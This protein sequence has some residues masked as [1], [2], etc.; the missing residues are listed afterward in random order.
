MPVVMMPTSTLVRMMPTKVTVNRMAFC[1]VFASMPAIVPPS[2]AQSIVFQMEVSR[3][4]SVP[5]T[6]DKM[7]PKMTQVAN[8]TM[9]NATMRACV[10]LTIML[11]K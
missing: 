7:M 1:P 9:V 2:S 11:W 10:P 3:L 4:P 8:V 5:G 6:S